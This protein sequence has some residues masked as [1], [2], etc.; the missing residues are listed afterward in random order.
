MKDYI[1]LLGEGL[2]PIRIET[3][4]NSELCLQKLFC[5]AEIPSGRKKVVGTG[6][7]TKYKT[8]GGMST[9]SLVGGYLQSRLKCLLVPNLLKNVMYYKDC[10]MKILH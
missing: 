10:W 9:G 5:T 7:T 1:L 3:K 4:R 8:G 6:I 2:D